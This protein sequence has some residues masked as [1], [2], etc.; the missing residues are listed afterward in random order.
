MAG[1]KGLSGWPVAIGNSEVNSLSVRIGD[2]GATTTWSVG[3]RVGDVLRLR[4]LRIGADVHVWRQ[5]PPLAERTYDPLETGAAIAAVTIIPLPRL[6][7]T[8]WSNGIHLTTGVKSEGYIP[9]EL[10]A[11]G[12]Y[13]RAGITL[14]P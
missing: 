5:P 12:G 6:L 11:G 3:A 7:R 9:G 10:L 2:T 13:L 8:R 14:A 4:G 1:G